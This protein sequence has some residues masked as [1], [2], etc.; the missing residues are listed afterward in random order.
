MLK[1]SVASSY[2][3]KFKLPSQLLQK[4]REPAD[5]PRGCHTGQGVEI[6][7]KCKIKLL[8]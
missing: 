2:S 4:A 3:F 8:I 7:Q 5:T 1:F 6:R